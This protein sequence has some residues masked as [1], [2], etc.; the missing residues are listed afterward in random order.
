MSIHRLGDPVHAPHGKEDSASVR[1]RQ[2]PLS[3]TGAKNVEISLMEIRR[4]G[5]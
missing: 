1:G 2:L 4:Y 3:P 5:V